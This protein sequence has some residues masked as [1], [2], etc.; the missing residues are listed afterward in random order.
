MSIDRQVPP[1]WDKVGRHD[2]FPT[3]SHDEV[4]RFNFLTNLNMYLATEVIPGVRT[5][6]E[7]RVEPAYRKEHGHAPESRHEVRKL[8][9]QDDYFQ[10]WS[11][12]RRSTMEMRQQAGRSMVLRQVD[13]LTAAAKQFND[14]AETLQLNPELPLPGYVSAV[15][16]HCMPG[17]YFSALFDD[18]ISAGANYDCGIF[19]TTAGL[20]GAYSDGG[21]KAIAEWL[22]KEHPDFKP[23]RILDI[24]TTIGHNIVPIAQ[25]FPDAEVI[26][27]D[28][29]APVLR[30]GH[31][32]A[33]SLG[34]NNIT[35][36]Q[37]NGEDLPDYED[38][39]FDLITTSM[40]FHETS[41]KAMPRI[42]KSIH[43]LLKPGGI[44]LNLEQ[45]QYEGMPVFEQFMRDWDTYNNNEPFWGT[46]HDIDLGKMLTESGFDPEQQFAIKV[47]PSVD[48]RIFPPTSHE[49]KGEDYGRAPAWDAFG[50]RKPA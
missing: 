25:S 38:G 1:T 48:T 4:A 7:T 31:A 14:G 43:R 40:F 11:A 21:G 50:M 49:S 16:I 8:M 23:R 32:R 27:I 24:G 20:L 18:D 17:S 15:D 26:A 42:L 30:Y 28:V 45:P 19:V 44:A 10:L 47:V 37:A 6:Y 3:P 2:V 9:N 13:Q 33:R 12:L 35:F 36:V 34:V 46:M 5:A 29:S 22:Q 41:S 39:S